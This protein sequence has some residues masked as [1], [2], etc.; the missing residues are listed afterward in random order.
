MFNLHVVHVCAFSYQRQNVGPEYSKF[1]MVKFAFESYI[2]LI[3]LDVCEVHM[4]IC[5]NVYSLNCPAILLFI[6]IV[7]N[8]NV[9][10]YV[11]T[12]QQNCFISRGSGPKWYISSM[13]YS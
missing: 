9:R 1:V 4:D 6:N 7:F 10:Q 13:L 8:F 11:Q 2:W 12:F 3:L 5:N